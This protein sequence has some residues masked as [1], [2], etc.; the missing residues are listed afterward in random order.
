MFQVSHSTKLASI[1]TARSQTRARGWTSIG[2]IL[3]FSGVA[4]E[5]KG[6]YD[7]LIPSWPAGDST[8]P[9]Y[10]G[11]SACASPRIDSAGLKTFFNNGDAHCIVPAWYKSTY[12][13]AGAFASP[14]Y[15]FNSP[16][17]CCRGGG[18]DARS[19]EMSILTSMIN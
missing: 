11:A 15:K 13:G 8:K 12:E 14:R 16:K 18:T 9:T 6:I 19:A 10:V 4:L 17:P 5:F 3:N 2:V 7:L 1:A